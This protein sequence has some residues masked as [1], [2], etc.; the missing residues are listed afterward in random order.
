MERKFGFAKVT[1]VAILALSWPHM[2]LATTWNIP[3][4]QQPNVCMMQ[5]LDDYTGALVAY[6]QGPF[7][8]IVDVSNSDLSEGSIRLAGLIYRIGFESDAVPYWID[9]SVSS[10]KILTIP[11]D[12][13]LLDIV[14]HGDGAME[15]NDTGIALQ[16]KKI[17]IQWGT[18]GDRMMGYWWDCVNELEE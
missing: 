3:S 9:A 11:V 17:S 14:F 7:E 15:F 10:E 8:M 12:G 1:G 4:S 5:A 13:N 18:P 6:A 2:G 16:G